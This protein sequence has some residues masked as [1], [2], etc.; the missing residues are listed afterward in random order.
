MKNKPN[1]FSSLLLRNLSHQTATWSMPDPSNP[2]PFFFV[3]KI[4]EVDPV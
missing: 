2:F 3:G 4:T 1:Y